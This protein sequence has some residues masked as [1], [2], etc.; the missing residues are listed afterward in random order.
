MLSAQ[1]NFRCN[2]LVLDEIFDNLD[3]T[4]SEKVLDLISA[5]LNDVE[6]IFIITHHASIPVP[7]DKEIIV[8]KGDD[9]LS[10]IL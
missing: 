7:Y 8:Q 5:K 3:S 2:I 9:N 1:T 6:N 4:G 10:V